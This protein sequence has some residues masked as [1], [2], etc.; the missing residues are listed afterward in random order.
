MREQWRISVLSDGKEQNMTKEKMYFLIHGKIDFSADGGFGDRFIDFCRRE[1]VSLYNFSD[2]GETF[3]GSTERKNLKALRAA[4]EKSGMNIRIIKRSGLPFWFFRY[5]RRYGLP[6][7]AVLF[8]VIIHIL[9]M[10]LWSVEITG[11]ELITDEAVESILRDCGVKNGVFVSSL[12]CDDIEYVLYEKLDGVL[13]VSVFNAGSRLF[14]DIREKVPESETAD[15]KS[16]SN[17]VASKDGEI[18]RADIFSGEG[19]IPP[20]TPVLKG[21]LLVSGVV[22]LSDES[23]RFVNSEA[24]IYARTKN[25]VSSSAPLEAQVLTVEKCK[26]DYFLYIFGAKLFSGGFDKYNCFTDSCRYFESRDVIFPVGLV[27]RT[28]YSL[29]KKQLKLSTE[30]ALLLSFSD[31][32]KSAFAIYKNADVLERSISVSTRDQVFT[33]GVFL[34]E[35]NIALEKSFTVEDIR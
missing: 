12:Q 19:K 17:I 23:V 31:F 10:M 14:V 29:E 18:I 2:K 33:E 15:D 25:T 5:R 34:C 1:G 6:L 7:G 16:Y 24:D 3:S 4:A 35:E 30:Q 13:W 27:R 22:T 20:G 26:D 9:S 28:S 32:S 11:N 8:L 21:D